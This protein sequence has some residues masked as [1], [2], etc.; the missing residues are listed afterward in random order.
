M[1]PASIV[2]AA[3]IA[4]ISQ[5]ALA[6]CPPGLD[7]QLLLAR[8]AKPNKSSESG[9]TKLPPKPLSA[10]AINIFLMSRWNEFLRIAS[11][12]ITR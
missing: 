9:M 8:A 11:A 10:R 5:S 4:I 1:K 6:D 7:V 12:P 2:F 3:S